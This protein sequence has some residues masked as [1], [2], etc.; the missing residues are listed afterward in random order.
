MGLWAR[1]TSWATGGVTLA[2]DA[3]WCRRAGL[4]EQFSAAIMA[5][6][7]FVSISSAPAIHNA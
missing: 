1:R 3:L 7:Q 2:G 4:R 5:L 6:S